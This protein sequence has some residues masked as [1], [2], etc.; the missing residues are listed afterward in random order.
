ML[1]HIF[2]RLDEMPLT[3]SGKINRKVLPEV[4]LENISNDTEYVKP[5]T[6][7]QKEIDS[8]MELVLKHSPIGLDDD[9]FDCGGD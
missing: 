7:L 9:F 6:E 2:T 5:Q 4:V 3:P 1:P 8:L